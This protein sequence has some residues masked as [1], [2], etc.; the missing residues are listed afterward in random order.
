MENTKYNME[1]KQRTEQ[2]YPLNAFRLC[3]DEYGDDIQ[4]RIYSRMSEVPLVFNNFSE[5]L[6]KADTLFDEK[7]YPQ[8]FQEKRSFQKPDVQQ[9]R[10]AVPKPVLEAEKVLGQSGS[11]YTLDVLVQSRRRAGWQGRILCRDKSAM[12][13]Y[14]SEM[15][16]MTC[17]LNE[18]N[19]NTQER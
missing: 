2:N 10:Y 12:P 16:L 11:F 13:E 17:I 4:G 7:G 14:R 9:G 6:L 8:A 19:E 18:L 5:M 3:I 15:E 1:E